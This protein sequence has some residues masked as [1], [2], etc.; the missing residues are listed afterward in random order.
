MFSKNTDEYLTKKTSKRRPNLIEAEDG[1]EYV[2]KFLKTFLEQNITKKSLAIL[3]DHQFL[4]ENLKER[5]LI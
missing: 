2:D 1:K 4:L 5:Y 3:Q